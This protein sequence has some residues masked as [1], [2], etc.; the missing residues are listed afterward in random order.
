MI[1][2]ENPSIR[3]RI[4]QIRILSAEDQ[5]SIQYYEAA[6]LAQSVLHDTVGGG[7]PIMAA[8]ESALKAADWM[9]AVAASKKRNYPIRAWCASE[10]AADHRA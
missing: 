8:I 3:A 1:A 7:H 4:E 5:G 2:N 6:F 9:R 10:S